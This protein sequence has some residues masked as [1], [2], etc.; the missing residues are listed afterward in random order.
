MRDFLASEFLVG[1]LKMHAPSKSLADDALEN[2]Y[3]E[4]D[5]PGRINLMICNRFEAS[6]GTIPQVRD[7]LI[8]IIEDFDKFI[9]KDAFRSIGFAIYLLGR[10]NGSSKNRKTSRALNSLMAKIDKQLDVQT[11]AFEAMKLQLIR[12]SVWITQIRLRER[13]AI[14]TYVRRVLNDNSEAS[15][16]RGFHLIYYGDKRP[17]LL[18]SAAGRE[19]LFRKVYFD[20]QQG[21]GTTWSWRST[22]YALLA[23]LSQDVQRMHGDD[24]PQPDFQ[25]RLATLCSFIRSRYSIAEFAERGTYLIEKLHGALQ[26]LRTLTQ[27]GPDDYLIPE[28]EAEIETIIRDSYRGETG[29]WQTLLDLYALKI[30]PRAGWVRR[31]APNIDPVRRTESVAEHAFF[32]ARLALILLPPECPD[33]KEY[34]RFRIVQLLL[35]HDDGQALIGDYVPSE[36]AHAAERIDAREREAVRYLDRRLTVALDGREIG[37]YHAFAEFEAQDTPNARIA[38]YVCRL[39]TLIQLCIYRLNRRIAERDYEAFKSN[40]LGFLRAERGVCGGLSE[41]AQKFVAWIEKPAAR[42]SP[43]GGYHGLRGEELG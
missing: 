12:R 23:R 16:N 7:H 19:E 35:S 21:D 2:L 13:D 41:K 3:F 29:L 6:R 24:A 43:P 37:L 20:E 10:L 32:A 30:E 33:E 15:L 26:A 36:R 5:F 4:A 18:N 1:L 38:R 25:L 8:A 9:Q 31:G 39:E 17:L 42:V 22:L 11:N 28:L 14:Q 27:S 40:L 34:D